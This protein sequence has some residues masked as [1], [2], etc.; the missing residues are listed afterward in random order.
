MTEDKDPDIEQWKKELE[1]AWR[2]IPKAFRSDRAVHG[3]LQCRLF[4][5][6][7]KLGFR[8]VADYMPPRIM[9]RSVDIIAVNDEN[10]VVHAVC[11]E[12][13][14]TLAAVKS[15]N[16]FAAQNKL[17]LT[18]GPL[19]KKVQESKFFLNEEIKHAHLKPFER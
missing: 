14:V 10:A 6:V 4:R 13:V 17:I 19:E 2:R 16:S 1:E 15:L 7:E 3:T 8:T 12:T 9:D 18:T 11:I 5:I